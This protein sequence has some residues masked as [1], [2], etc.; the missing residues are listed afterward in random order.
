MVTNRE[1]G[2]QK[3]RKL[4][5]VDCERPHTRHTYYVEYVYVKRNKIK[6]LADFCFEF[7]SDNSASL[8]SPNIPQRYQLARA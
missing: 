4:V 8:H 7:Q 3:F 6:Y 5:N 1:G 2:V